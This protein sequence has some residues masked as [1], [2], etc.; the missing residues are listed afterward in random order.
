MEGLG[1]RV[2]AEM[3]KSPLKKEG[4]VHRGSEG[5]GGRNIV[6]QVL[7]RRSDRK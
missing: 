5:K 3:E 6:N 2:A 1:E 7:N 4:N